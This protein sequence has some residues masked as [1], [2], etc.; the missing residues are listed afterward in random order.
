MPEK[1]TRKNNEPVLIVRPAVKS[2]GL[3]YLHVSLII[4]IVILAALAF[5]LSTFKGASVITC[6][7]GVSANGLCSNPIQTNGNV[8]YA[9]EQVLASY[10]IINS[11]LSLLP[12]YSL[13]NQAKISYLNN[14]SEWLVTIPYILPYAKNQTF[15]TSLILYDSNL[16]L[17][18]PYLSSIKPLFQSSNRAVGLGAVSIFGK[19]ACVTSSNAPLPIY[20]FVDPYAPG[21]LQGMM[22]GINATNQFGNKVNITYKFVFTGYATRFYSTYGINQTQQNGEDLWC[23]SRQST[24]KFSAFLQNYTKLFTGT[25]IQNTSLIQ[26]AQG[27][28]LNM[29]Q[30]NSCLV[31]APSKLNAQLVFASYYGIQQTP[32]YV[33]NCRYL[34]IPQT[35]G[36]GINYALNNT[37]Q[38]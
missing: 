28:G 4:L 32:S 10:G 2:L 34:T 30:F 25:P 14:Q 9:A 6:H 35:L 16:T 37:A 31:T 20:A 24:N 1:R 21:A 38:G 23:A 5:S 15:Y 36:Y 13:P 12:Y 19:S 8:L 26:V 33:V 29:T 18:Q 11:S 7:Y 22:S 17:A 27:S 3:D